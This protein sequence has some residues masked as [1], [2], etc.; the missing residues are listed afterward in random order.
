VPAPF[1][2]AYLALFRHGELAR[3]AERARK[4]LAECA[5]CARSCHSDRLAGRG[6][7]CRTGR[8]AVVSSAFPH[9]GEEDCLRGTG[10]SGTI[11]FGWCNLRCSFCQ[12][13]E[14][15]A[16][17]EGREVTAA[18]LAKLMLQLQERGCHNIN[19]VSPSHVVAQILEALVIA[20]ASGLRLPL[21]Y[22]TGAYDS[23]TALGLLDGV[24]DIYMPDFKFWEPACA[25]RYAKAEDYPEVARAA[26]REMHRQVGPLALD[27]RGIA[28]RGVLLRHLVMPNGV[29]G[30]REIMQWVARELSPDT[31][32]NIMAQYHPAG[33][34][35]DFPELRS[36]VSTFE[37]QRAVEDARAAGL[38]RLDAHSLAGRM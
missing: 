31:Y 37:F 17:G 20:V 3:R 32:V 9:H 15:S 10:G 18:Q 35:A 26:I 11:F 19:L 33:R 25:Q 27:E 21:V 4:A 34:A 24:I 13:W 36:R 2:P 22:N 38:H 29:A 12:N 5:L 7:I 16:E 28:Q 14:L 8:L 1:E 6:S 30:T 23:L